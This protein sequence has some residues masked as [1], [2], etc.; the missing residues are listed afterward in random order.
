MTAIS[1]LIKTPKLYFNDTGLACYLL[2]IN[3]QKQLD[4]HPLY[5]QLF[6][7]Y[8]VNEYLKYFTNH[9]THSLMY[10]FRNRRGLEADVLLDQGLKF[11]LGEI[12]SA[13]TVSSHPFDNLLKIKEL[14]NKPA[15][16]NLI[17]G[18]QENQKRTVGNL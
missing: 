16:L 18:G 3:H 17:Y 7:T 2:G 5:G 13:H 11:F 12:K 8:I 15:V 9:Q 6:E 4:T 1:K 14:L 10:F